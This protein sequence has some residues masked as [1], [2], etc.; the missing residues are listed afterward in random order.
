MEFQHYP[1]EIDFQKYWLILKRHWI[2]ATGAFLLA[3]CGAAAMAFTAEPIY[4]AQGKLLLKKKNTTSALVTDASA[5]VGELDTLSDKD[6]P[7]DTEAEV[8]RSTPIAEEV[9]ASMGLLSSSG[10]PMRPE[11]FLRGLEVKTIRG[12]DVLLITYTS[13]DPQEAANVVNVLMEIYIKENIRANRAEATAARTFIT[14]LLPQTEANLRQAEARLRDFKEQNGVISLNEEARTA[15]ESI[16]TLS[17]MIAQSEAMLQD[18][19]ARSEQLQR[20]LGMDA[21]QAIAMNAVGESPA[22]QQALLDLQQIEDELAVARTRYQEQHPAI[23][24]LRR[25]Q[26]ALQSLVQE[27]V[28]QVLNG[29]P[30]SDINPSYQSG[31]LH[32]TLTSS[33]VELENQRRGL[34]EQVTTLQQSQVQY[35]QRANVLP[36]LEQQQRDLERQLATYQSTY[37]I[38]SRNLQQVQIVENQNVGNARIVSSASF[39]NKPVGPKKKVV[40]MGGMVVGGML[41]L[42][43]AFVFE[44]IDPSV[45]TAKEIRSLYQYTLLGM[46]P[47]SKKK[48]RWFRPGSD[49]STPKVVVQEAPHSIVSENYRML[50]ANL[51]FLSPDRELKVVIVT[52]PVPQEGK[53]TVSAN[54]AAAMAQLGRRVLL[55]DADMRHPMQHHIWHLTNLAGLSNV[56]MKQTDLSEAINPVMDNLD[57]LTCGAIPPNPLA[58][59]DSQRMQS[60]VQEFGRV[61]DFVIIDT[62]PM[63]LMADALSLA[64]MTDGI[65]LVSRPGVIDTVTARA[66]KELLNQSGQPVLGLVV[67][68]VMLDNEPDNYLHHAQFYSGYDESAA[69]PTSTMVPH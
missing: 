11:S 60:L 64:K 33:L 10:K 16:A 20:S 65:L 21:R 49:D 3:V 52:S 26:A 17:T 40:L 9:I 38:L 1:E 63:V 13:D 51:R 25:K 2:P 43:V 47:R 15:V 5:K 12:T 62:P 59:L 68:G 41:Y 24:N 46:I 42:I 61:Y 36:Q 27:R 58:L 54:L 55:V 6:T 45:K 32:R 44:L 31:T 67:N 18:T 39:P 37:D 7:L 34:R 53:S 66:A 56:I 69:T 35:Q 50:Q 28:S 19:A 48:R 4:E 29:T 14:R 22:V 30:S 8:I 57:V 23:A